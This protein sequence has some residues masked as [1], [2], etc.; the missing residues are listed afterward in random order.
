[1]CESESEKRIFVHV[2]EEFDEKIAASII[3]NNNKLPTLYTHSH[4]EGSTVC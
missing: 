4:I 3:R 2:Q 1:M